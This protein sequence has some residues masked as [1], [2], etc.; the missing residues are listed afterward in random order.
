MRVSECGLSQSDVAF[1][2]LVAESVGAIITRGAKPDSR[3]RSKRHL[4]LFDDRFGASEQRR[5]KSRRSDGGF[6]AGDSLICFVFGSFFCLLV[7]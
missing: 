4:L 2:L 7:L 3:H 5:R 6:C 1:L